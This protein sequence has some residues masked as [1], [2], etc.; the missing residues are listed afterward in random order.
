M[1]NGG[2]LTLRML[3]WWFQCYRVP[4]V[5]EFHTELILESNLFMKMKFKS[6]D[7]E[8]LLLLGLNSSNWVC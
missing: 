1:L 3:W 2:H 7:Y 8:L 6:P 5:L 4:N